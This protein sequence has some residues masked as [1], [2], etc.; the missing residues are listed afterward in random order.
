MAEI[1]AKPAQSM[2]CR[3]MSTAATPLTWAGSKIHR[4]AVV[5][6]RFFPSE[7]NE[8]IA[9]YEARGDDLATEATTNFI[10]LQWQLVPYRI[11]K[12]RQELDA[13]CTCSEC[14]PCAMTYKEWVRTARYFVRLMFLFMFGVMAGRASI[15]PLIGPDSIFADEMLKRP[16]QGF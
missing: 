3:V 8:K 1:A 5:A 4:R 16:A 7:L 14:S 2:L 6:Q 15:H 11:T 12:L 10:K 13:L 9:S